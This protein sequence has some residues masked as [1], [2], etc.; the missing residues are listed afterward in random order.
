MVRQHVNS[1]AIRSIGICLILHCP[2]YEYNAV[3]KDTRGEAV[4][5]YLPGLWRRVGRSPGQASVRL[6]PQD[7]R[8]V[9]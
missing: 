5:S 4:H 3:L 9:L 2:C 6:L 7:L 1:R 8:D